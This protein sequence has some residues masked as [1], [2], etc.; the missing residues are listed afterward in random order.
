MAKNGA[1]LGI[2]ETSV[3]VP[4]K[5]TPFNSPVCPLMKSDGS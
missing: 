3:V 4:S 5:I 1:I 2:L